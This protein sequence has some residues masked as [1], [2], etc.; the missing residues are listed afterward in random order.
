M[1]SRTLGGRVPQVENGCS[2][3]TN[4]RC[5]SKHI[6]PWSFWLTLFTRLRLFC[7]QC[8]PLPANVQGKVLAIRDV[9]EVTG[10]LRASVTLPPGNES[11]YTLNMRLPGRRHDLDVS[12]ERETFCVSRESNIGTSII[13]LFYIPF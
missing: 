10:K 4:C 9:K 12:D 13:T 3:L 7:S 6:R 8:R 2:N 11:R 5:I 1:S